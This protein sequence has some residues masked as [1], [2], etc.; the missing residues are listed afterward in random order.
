MAHNGTGS[1]PVGVLISCLKTTLPIVKNH[2][3]MRKNIALAKLD[4][5]LTSPIDRYFREANAFAD[6]RFEDKIN[7]S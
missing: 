7:N 6:F 3:F 5:F 2:L 1:M 4:E